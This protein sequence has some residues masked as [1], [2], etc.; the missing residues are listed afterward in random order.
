MKKL[1]IFIT[2]F[3]LA[4]CGKQVST[5]GQ[6]KDLWKCEHRVG[7]YYNVLLFKTVEE[8]TKECSK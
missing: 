4:S 3:T 1:F 5:A 2:L 6:N 7:P 8:A